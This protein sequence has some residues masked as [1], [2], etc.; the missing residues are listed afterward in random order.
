MPEQQE[1]VST[2]A[3]DEIVAGPDGRY[4]GKHLLFAV[5][6]IVGGFWF[7]YD[8]WIGWPKHN[9]EVQAVQRDI[10]QAR[11]EK[12]KDELKTKLA[13]MH[14]R[15]TE[16]DL[17]IQKL[18]A[19]VLP[20][21][22]VAYGV[23]TMAATRGQYRLAGNTLTIPGAEPIDLVDINRIDKARWDRKGIA[24]VYYEAHHPRRT[25]TFRLD[26]FAYQRGPTDEILARIEKF[27]APPGEFEPAPTPQGFAVKSPSPETESADG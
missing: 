24:V 15:Y 19:V 5:I 21:V 25:K 9:D 27:L 8:G 17:L 22:G 26:D 3:D 13:T 4:R 10:D 11:D 6:M 7:A 14:R 12:K 18:I 16:A 23:W 2:T 20:I 1:T